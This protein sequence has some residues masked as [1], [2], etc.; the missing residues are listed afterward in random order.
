[1][2]ILW[3]LDDLGIG[4]LEF[5]GLVIGSNDIEYCF[6]ENVMDNDVM[7]FVCKDCSGI[8]YMLYEL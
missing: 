5:F 7:G 1:M 2:F 4:D 6:I 3:N 8:F